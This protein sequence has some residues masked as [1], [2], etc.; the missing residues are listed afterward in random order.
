MSEDFAGRVAIVTGASRGLGRVIASALVEAGASVTVTARSIESAEAAAKGIASV[1]GAPM[2]TLGLA[3]DV[4]KPADVEAMVA[5]T[6]E[7]FGRVDVL[8]NNAGIN[9]RGPIEDLPESA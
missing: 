7:A 2:R 1:D 8:V 9:I 6:V 3:V 4:T 5:R